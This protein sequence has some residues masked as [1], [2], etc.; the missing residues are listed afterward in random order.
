LAEAHPAAVALAAEPST[1][2]AAS[3]S[4]ARKRPARD[5][6]ARAASA[7]TEIAPPAQGML[8]IA[9]SPW[10]QVEVDGR[11]VGT[12]PPL[13][14]LSLSE[15]S[16]HIVVRNED[17]APFSTTVTVSRDKPVTVKHRFGS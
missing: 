1:V 11:P 2:A 5:L 3:A 10:G 9:I 8:N 16:H 15:G 12:A 14:T 17:F 4:A 7:P 13:A 6:R